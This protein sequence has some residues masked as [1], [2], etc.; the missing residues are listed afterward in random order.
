[1]NFNQRDIVLESKAIK[2]SLSDSQFARMCSIM[3]FSLTHAGLGIFFTLNGASS[4]PKRN[5]ARQQTIG[6]ARLRQVVFHASTKKVIIVLDK[7]DIF[8]LNQSGS[9][10]TL[11]IRKT[12]D[13]HE[14]S[15][16]PNAPVEEFV[17]ADL[18]ESPSK[19]KQI[20]T[21]I[22]NRKNIIINL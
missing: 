9:L 10:I 11:L 20:Y 22:C 12:R 1:M 17:E 7:D 13:L 5:Q 14:L 15:G 18:P 16:V 21:Q 8:T 3:T 2:S 19:L 6:N 4:F